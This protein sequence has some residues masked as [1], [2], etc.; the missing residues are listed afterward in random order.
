VLF[1]GARA[2][3]LG[4]KAWTAAGGCTYAGRFGTPYDGCMRYEKSAMAIA[5]QIIAIN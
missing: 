2:L 1:G 3:A 4:I 5:K